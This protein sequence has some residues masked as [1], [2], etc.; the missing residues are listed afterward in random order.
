MKKTGNK[1][2]AAFPSSASHPNLADLVDRNV[3]EEEKSNGYIEMPL[4][5]KPEKISEFGEALLSSLS[6]HSEN[7]TSTTDISELKIMVKN[8]SELTPLELQRFYQPVLKFI[9]SS[10]HLSSLIL[11]GSKDEKMP[12]SSTALMVMLLSAAARNPNIRKLVLGVVKVPVEPFASV[13]ARN[14]LIQ[15][16]LNWCLWESFDLQLAEQPHLLV[17][18][19]IG[20]NTSITTLKLEKIGHRHVKAV[21]RELAVQRKTMIQHLCVH[22]EGAVIATNASRRTVQDELSLF[23]TK[24][25]SLQHLELKSFRLHHAVFQPIAEALRKS[26]S[27]VHLTFHMCS[28]CNEDALS[29]RNL[30]TARRNAPV[31][32]NQ[33]NNN[34]ATDNTVASSSTSEKQLS[35]SHILADLLKST[36]I[37]TNLHFKGVNYYLYREDLEVIL[38]ALKQPDCTVTSLQLGSIRDPTYCDTLLEYLP[39][40]WQLMRLNV[41]LANTLEPTFEKVLHAVEKNS[42][43]QEIHI[44]ADFLKRHHQELLDYICNRNLQVPVIEENQKRGGMAASWWPTVMDKTLQCPETAPTS[45]FQDRKSVV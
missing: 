31:N 8:D 4:M 17:A 22:S 35:T 33:Q 15:L 7:F 20:S 18:R 26:K 42:S 41:E 9:E 10:P 43:L 12:T 19:A 37:L 1:G 25:P 14:K 28:F 38:S 24:I 39:Q 32:T 11:D 40:M 34:T 13:L 30:F 21:L 3:E 6:A 45:L 16:E 2:C 27:V 23:I 29:L 44:Q 36:K 5:E